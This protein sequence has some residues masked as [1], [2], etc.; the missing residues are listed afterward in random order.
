LEKQTEQAAHVV[1]KAENR[2]REAAENASM[3]RTIIFSVAAAV[4]QNQRQKAGRSK[5]TI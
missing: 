2:S 1:C 3:M 4:Q 5:E